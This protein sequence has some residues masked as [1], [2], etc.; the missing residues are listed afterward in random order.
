M[1]LKLYQVTDADNVINKTLPDDPLELTIRLKRDTDIIN[2]M[3][4]LSTQEGID[5]N[6][7]NYA[8]IEELERYYF[9]ESVT[10]LNNVRWQFFLSCDVL[11][12]YKDE[13]FNSHALFKR[14]L[15]HGDYLNTG[16]FD[17]SIIESIETYKSNVILDDKST[18]ILTALSKSKESPIV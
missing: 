13:I 10:N 4:I 18:V 2:P 12:T 15:K 16:N 7:Y 17:I 14:Q 3:I 1:K 5:Y 8:Y 6:D 11:E 9:I